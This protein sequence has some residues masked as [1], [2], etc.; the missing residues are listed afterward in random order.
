[1]A[2]LNLISKA[3]NIMPLFD[4]PYFILTD[5]D[6][7][8]RF[9][10]L[11]SA[12]S[13]PGVDGDTVNNMQA[14]AR[15]VNL[16]LRVRPGSV[17]EDMRDYVLSYVKPMQKAT[18]Q[19]QTKN[20]LVELVGLCEAVE[21]P[22]FTNGVTMLVSFHCEEPFWA[23]ALTVVQEIGYVI[24]KHY[25]PPGGL[26]FPEEG[27]PF[28]LYD[29]NRTTAFKNAGDVTVGM[30]IEIVA[31]ANVTNPTLY[32]LETGAFMK[33]TETMKAGDSIVITTHKGNKT[34]TK[35]GVNII[36]KLTLDSTWLLLETGEKQFMI[37]TDDTVKNNVYFRITYKQKYV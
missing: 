10:A 12:S 19:L 34:I 11:L 25:F 22:R 13:V 30:N 23:D 31:L 35:N 5:C 17:V 1:M 8:T 26:A 24:N 18:L 32:D 21:M 27:L 33:I 36:D 6:G 37:D 2:V 20:R 7:M 14:Q 29:F 4:N 9:T 3:G 16:Y 15:T 28:G